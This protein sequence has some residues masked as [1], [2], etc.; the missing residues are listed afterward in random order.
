MS[1][2][3]TIKK[4]AAAAEIQTDDNVTRTIKSTTQ[5]LPHLVRKECRFGGHFLRT[6][7]KNGQT[8]YGPY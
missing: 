5:M 8:Q 6:N 2:I 4:A 1:A 7:S 3:N